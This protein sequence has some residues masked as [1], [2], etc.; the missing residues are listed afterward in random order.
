MII[1]F[2]R[3][4]N[5]LLCR[6]VCVRCSGGLARTCPLSRCGR[7]RTPISRRC[8]ARCVIRNRSGWRR[9]PPKTQATGA[10]SILTWP[11]SEA[12]DRICAA[13]QP[14]VT[15]VIADLTTT[16][17]CDSSGV[18]H[19]LLAHERASASEVQLRFAVPSDC[20]VRRVLKLTGVHRVLAVY[21]TL[22]EAMTGGL[23]PDPAGRAPSEP[24]AHT[25]P[26]GDKISISR[27][28]WVL[29]SRPPP[30]DWHA[31]ATITVPPDPPYRHTRVFAWPGDGQRCSV[32]RGWK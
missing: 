9:S 10:P 24:A 14:G 2:A 25:H 27:T 23:P 29:R 7:S 17:F 8:S 22:A 5:A 12:S 1:H 16:T 32:M 3:R 4:F 6:R 31:S 26:F 11:G 18:R 19:L 30:G 28:G 15:E 21:P 13:F 20:P